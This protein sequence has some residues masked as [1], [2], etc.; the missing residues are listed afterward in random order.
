MTSASRL[1]SFPSVFLVLVLIA[2]CSPEKGTE[3]L[4]EPIPIRIGEIHPVADYETITVSG[5]VVSPHEPSTVSFLVSGKVDFVGPR[6]GDY[7]KRGQRIAAID[8]LDYRLGVAAA[9]AQLEQAKVGLRR[10]EDEYERM[11]FLYDSKSLAPNDYEKFKATL[12]TAREKVRQAA[13]NDQLAQKHLSDAT[14]VAPIDGYID[15]R[16][17]EP[18]ETASPGKPVFRIARLDPVE[19]NVG[20]PETDIHRVRIGQEASI[21]FPA[22]PNQSFQGTV[23]IINVAA[24]PGTRTYMTRIRVPNPRHVIR[25]GMVAE[26]KIVGDQK[27]SMMTVPGE[28]I[29]RDDQGATMVFVYFPEQRRVYSN[30]VKIGTF[31]GTEVEIKEGLSGNESIVIAGQ[32]HLRDGMLVTI[33]T[34]PSE[35]ASDKQRGE[36][37]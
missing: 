28:A 20:V 33:A 35:K 29:V 17:I 12:D 26:A 6:E 8:P 3:S 11:K 32:D 31:R 1:V 15:M 7:V 23:R 5:S 21:T 9:A 14:L 13:A 16:A 22:L 27:I 36:A 37:Q 25:I 30:R 19:I 34:P 24:D 18:G 10:A 4:S 2:S